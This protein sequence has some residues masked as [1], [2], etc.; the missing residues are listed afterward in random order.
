MLTVVNSTTLVTLCNFHWLRCLVNE[1][2]Q[3][4]CT[5]VMPKARVVPLKRIT[6]PR[7]ELSAATVAVRLDKMKK[8]E[9]ELAVDRS[10]FGQ[11]VHRC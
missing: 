10:F 2:G 4:H 1:S 9:L 3:I 8:R 6:I 5:F 11:I 7:L